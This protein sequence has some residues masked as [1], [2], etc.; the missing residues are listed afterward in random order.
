MVDFTTIFNTRT[1]K[2]TKKYASC[3]AMLLFVS[4]HGCEEL[5]GSGRCGCFLVPHQAVVVNDAI[6]HCPLSIVQVFRIP[7]VSTW[8][9]DHFIEVVCL[10]NV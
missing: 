8:S 4:T 9:L 3:D 10:R 6:V 2:Q 1:I 5:K 7:H